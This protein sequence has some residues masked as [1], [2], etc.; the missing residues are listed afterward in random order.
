MVVAMHNSEGE[1]RNTVSNFIG[2]PDDPLHSL[3]LS[4]MFYNG[5]YTPRCSENEEAKRII[6][7]FF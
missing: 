5:K 2:S 6:V 1:K 4:N 3:Q 7:S